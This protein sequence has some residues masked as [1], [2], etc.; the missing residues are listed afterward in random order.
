MALQSQ[1]ITLQSVLVTTF[2]YGPTSPD[3]IAH[4]LSNIYA[5]SRVAAASSV[6]VLAALQERLQDERPLTPRSMH[7][8]T[9]R[10]N[11]THAPSIAP[12]QSI[13]QAP[14]QHTTSHAP[15]HH[16]SYVPTHAPSYAASQ[17]RSRAR[18]QT[19]SHAPTYVSHHKTSHAP[20]HSPSYHTSHAPSRAL[21]LPP[22]G[23][24]TKSASTALMK[25]D[26]PRT[27]HMRSSSPVNTTILDWRDRTA[28]DITS[29]TGPTSTSMQSASDDL[30]CS[31]AVDLQRDGT[32]SL[33]ACITSNPSP[34]CPHC[35]GDLH[36]S[37]GKAWEISKWDNDCE[38]TFQ[39]QNRF[40]V[41]CHRDGPDG[42]YCC[43]ICTKYAD[44]DT[45]CGDVKALVKHLS[46][47]HDLRE[48]KH[49]EDIVE[50]IEQP[51]SRRDSGIGYGSARGSRR[52]ASLASSRRRKSLPGYEREVD[53]FEVGRS[54]R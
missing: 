28:T 17:S 29:M 37:P 53:I 21:T 42:Q 27:S 10:S 14:S 44:A 36:M 31:Y 51:V 20:S 47:E 13:S 3:P 4:Q 8:I 26:A 23:T 38:R 41:K 48:L 25:Y 49:E 24:G 15:T 45:V 19:L 43:V 6:E 39:V 18:S 34:Y 46:D 16:T 30:Y 22:T 7:S 35:K 5:A 32:K 11:P 1:I 50:V 54:R 52:S 40:V 12:S 33:S 2:L 9:A